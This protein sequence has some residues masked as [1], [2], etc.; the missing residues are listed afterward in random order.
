M[1]PSIL[2]WMSIKSGA[3]RSSPCHRELIER[4]S[5]A[6]HL[7]I[8]RLRAEGSPF[9]VASVNQGRKNCGEF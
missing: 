1:K 7:V 9:V 5:S 8:L 4:S 6:L 3:V 2:G